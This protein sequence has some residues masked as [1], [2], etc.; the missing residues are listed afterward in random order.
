MLNIE[1]ATLHYAKRLIFQSLNFSLAEGKWLAIMGTSGVGKTS[2]LRLI[3]GLNTLRPEEDTEISGTVTWQQQKKL[4][5]AY[6][7][8]QDG[9]F[10]WLSVM[11]NV[12]LPFH[13]SGHKASKIEALDLLKAVK[14]QDHAAHKPKTLSGGMRQRVALARTLIQHTPLVLMDEP[15]SALDAITRMKMQ[16]LSFDLLRQAKKTVLMVTHD[17]WEALRL[18]DTILVLGETPAKIIAK[19]DLP[20]STSLR[21]I[22]DSQVIK[23]YQDLMTLM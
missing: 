3:A 23:H 1:N 13:L 2:L 4:D 21:D 14:L 19:I 20:P 7:A 22:T 6:M 11:E 18:A 12:L 9:L 15:F 10:P 5:V 8:Q 16:A 17:P